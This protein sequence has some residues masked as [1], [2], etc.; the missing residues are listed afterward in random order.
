MPS[1]F[2]HEMCGF[3]YHRMSRVQNRRCAS[4]WEFLS[5][6]YALIYEYVLIQFST[7]IAMCYQQR[8]Y[9]IRLVVEYSN[10]IET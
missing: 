1:S 3:S 4:P 7:I 9:F 6:Y 5:G 8:V 2:K 10:I